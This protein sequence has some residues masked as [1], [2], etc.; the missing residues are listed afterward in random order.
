MSHKSR[1]HLG[2]LLGVLLVPVTM[3]SVLISADAA[4]ASTLQWSVPPTLM[5]GQLWMIKSN[6][7]ASL[8]GVGSYEWIGCGLTTAPLTPDNYTP[9]QP[10]QVPIFTDYS[11]FQ[12]AVLS[13]Q[14]TE[15]DTVIFD[16]E[17]WKYTPAWEQAQQILY[18]QLAAQLAAENGITFINAPYGKS[19]KTIIA[20]DV[21]A[22][23]YASVV[24]I[25][26]QTLDRNPKEYGAFVRKAVAAIRAANP[27]VP[28]LA[29]LATDAGG[30]PTS[31]NDMYR[32]YESVK[33]DVQGFWLNADT[34]GSPHSHGCASQGCPVTARSFL[35]MIG[36]SG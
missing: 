16:N 17:V 13:H 28:I 27:D 34:W 24:E 5:A 31:T 2:L 3:A 4:A 36:V 8:G 1:R 10:G 7:L 29:G 14:L 6:D 11:K 12:K 30:I 26:A 33:N 22:A 25:Q 9:C 15:G 35:K 32:E 20:E 23:K 21:G 19:T 18:E